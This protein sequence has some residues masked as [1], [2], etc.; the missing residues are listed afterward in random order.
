MPVVHIFND[1]SI[2]PFYMYTKAV[3]KHILYINFDVSSFTY[4]LITHLSQHPHFELYY[5]PN[6]YLRCFSSSLRFISLR[7][8]WNVAQYMYALR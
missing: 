1:L 5:Y 3:T 6:S 7:K 8:A 2:C 4:I